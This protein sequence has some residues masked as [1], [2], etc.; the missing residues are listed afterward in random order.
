MTSYATLHTNLG[1]I[2]I[3]LF[4]GRFLYALWMADH[5][6]VLSLLWSTSMYLLW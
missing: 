2:R 5:H 3:Q 1:D 4:D 6:R